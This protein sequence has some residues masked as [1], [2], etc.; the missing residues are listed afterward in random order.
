MP[1]D[2]IVGNPENIKNLAELESYLSKIHTYGQE[3]KCKAGVL[4]IQ[5]RSSKGSYGIVSEE[6]AKQYMSRPVLNNPRTP[7]WGIRF[8]SLSYFER[9]KQKFNG[10]MTYQ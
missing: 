1:V 5:R 10:N 2:T 7:E 3:G 4:L 6:E 9:L 8:Y